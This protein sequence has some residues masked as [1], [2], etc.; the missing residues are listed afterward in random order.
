MVVPLIRAAATLEA[1][2][3][4]II[5]AFMK[6]IVKVAKK[7]INKGKLDNCLKCPIALAINTVLS[8]S[9]KSEVYKEDFQIYHRD[10]DT[11]KDYLDYL[12]GGKLPKL[13]QGFINM[14]DKSDKNSKKLLSPFCLSL[15]IPKKFLK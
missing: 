11:D 4:N 15:N 13:G 7:Y 12:Y 1:E 5:P 3:N 14:F 8:K 10:T 9:Y 6:V 2:E